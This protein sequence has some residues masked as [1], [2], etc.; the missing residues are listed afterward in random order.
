[1]N[2]YQLGR[3]IWPMLALSSLM[4]CASLPQDNLP[5]HVEAWAKTALKQSPLLVLDGE[6]DGNVASRHALRKHGFSAVSPSDT[7][8]FV[9]RV[10]HQTVTE[11]E[12]DPFCDDG[13]FWARRGMWMTHHPYWS[14]PC[15]VSWGSYRYSSRLYWALEDPNGHII[16]QEMAQGRFDPIPYSQAKKLA[17]K[18]QAWLLE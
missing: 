18:L 7:P 2:T 10:R 8:S 17:D 15:W 4:G 16:W 9:L 12:P 11:R 6:Y 14:R 13:Y 5:P 3:M 1:M